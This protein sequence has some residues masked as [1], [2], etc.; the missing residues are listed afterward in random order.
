MGQRK[1][2]INRRTFLEITTPRVPPRNHV[3]HQGLS[4]L[5]DKKLPAKKLKE[6]VALPLME[7]QRHRDLCGSDAGPQ[8]RKARLDLSSFFPK[9]LPRGIRDLSRDGKYIQM[10]RDDGGNKQPAEEDASP[11]MGGWESPKTHKSVPRV[12]VSIDLWHPP[13]RTDTA[14]PVS[15]K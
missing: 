4:H 11:V 12:N 10:P 14:S 3:R 15:I 6:K 8:K 9:S 13:W 1:W 2:N 5:I 7:N